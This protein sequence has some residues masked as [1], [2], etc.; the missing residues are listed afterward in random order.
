MSLPEL[1]EESV[2]QTKT[3]LDNSLSKSAEKTL[4]AHIEE[5]HKQIALKMRDNQQNGAKSTFDSYL[6]T[7]AEGGNWEEVLR[8]INTGCFSVAE[9][10]SWGATPL[11]FASGS[12]RSILLSSLLHPTSHQ[13]HPLLC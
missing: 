5:I 4:R 9:S 1:K 8:L 2:V 12:G 6:T 11:H 10:N 7:H 13:Y 3:L